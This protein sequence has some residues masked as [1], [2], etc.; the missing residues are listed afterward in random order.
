MR[1]CCGGRHSRERRTQARVVWARARPR[2]PLAVCGRGVPRVRVQPAAVRWPSVNVCPVSACACVEFAVRSRLRCGVAIC[3]ARSTGR[4][5]VSDHG[6]AA[7]RV[8]LVSRSYRIFCPRVNV[9][10]GVLASRTATLRAP[11]R[12]SSRSTKTPLSGHRTRDTRGLASTRP[13][14]LHRPDS[15]CTSQLPVT[16]FFIFELVA[17]GL[18]PRS[19]SA[20]A[21]PGPPPRERYRLFRSRYPQRKPNSRTLPCPYLCG[22]ATS[23]S[24]STPGCAPCCM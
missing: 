6:S 23:E 16:S 24:K 3:V 17:D 4:S 12:V 21:G 19:G 8:R 9:A 13:S 2:S 15:I 7:G 18:V 5:A 10:H 14:R 1:G 20:V 11:A 22:Y